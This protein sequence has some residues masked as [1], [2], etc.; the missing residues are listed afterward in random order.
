MRHALSDAGGRGGVEGPLPDRGQ[1]LPEE[2]ARVGDRLLERPGQGPVEGGPVAGTAD[3]AEPDVDRGGRVAG[4]VRPD[5]LAGE[6]PAGDD[7]QGG[8]QQRQAVDRAGMVEGELQRDGGAG[9]MP[10]TWARRMPSRRISPWHCAAW[11]PIPR[12]PSTGS[13]SP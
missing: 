8:L 1:L 2:R 7:E 13:L 3:A 5:G 9:R 11:R 6:R 12:G 10:H 4:P